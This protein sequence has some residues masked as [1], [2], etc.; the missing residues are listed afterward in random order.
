MPSHLCRALVCLV[1]ASLGV[2]YIR[3]RKSAPSISQLKDLTPQ[4]CS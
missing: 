2:Q 3:L 1:H 4:K